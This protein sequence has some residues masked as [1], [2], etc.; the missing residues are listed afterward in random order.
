MADDP[1]GVDVPTPG[2]GSRQAAPP[3]RD[4]RAR[5][6]GYLDDLA[7]CGP[8]LAHPLAMHR[9]DAIAAFV[10]SHQGEL[11]AAGLP[12]DRRAELILCAASLRCAVTEG[13]W[14]RVRVDC[15]RITTMIDVCHPAVQAVPC[16]AGAPDAESPEPPAR[17]L[18]WPWSSPNTE[19][20]TLS[21]A[22]AAARARQ[23]MRT[24]S[25]APAG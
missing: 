18:R 4:A 20:I 3:D 7:R 13:R 12:V 9:A 11:A 23:S 21:E 22:V 19:G 17:E 16:A 25:D 10:S 2:P 15:A 1:L 5:I 6:C 14:V 24:E 8:R